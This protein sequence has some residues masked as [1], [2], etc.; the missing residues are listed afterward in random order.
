[1]GAWVG[2][3]EPGA[4]GSSSRFLFLPPRSQ[5]S[6]LDF[7]SWS[8]F[9]ARH[10]EF[11]SKLL[12]V[13]RRKMHPSRGEPHSCEGVSCMGGF[14]L[15]WSALE[16]GLPVRV[17]QL[18]QGSAPRPSTLGLEVGLFQGALSFLLRDGDTVSCQPV[19]RRWGVRPSVF[20]SSPSSAPLYPRMN[21]KYLEVGGVC[22]SFCV[23]QSGPGF[24][25]FSRPLAHFRWF[26]EEV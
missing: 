26:L 14:L 3:L 20:V 22:E 13:L 12:P 2:G 7:V 25:F 16:P 4:L 10:K 18:P 23:Y 9:H 5:F 8:I 1:M 24:S 11:V 15:G 17:S 6:F 21:R 19:V